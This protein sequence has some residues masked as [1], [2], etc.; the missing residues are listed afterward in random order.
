MSDS[1]PPSLPSSDMPT[2]SPTIYPTNAPS[3]STIDPTTNDPTIVPTLHPT[4]NPS[5]PSIAP[6]HQPTIGPSNHPTVGPSSH[7]TIAP[8]SHPTI[9]P[10]F[11]PTI[12]TTHPSIDPSTGPTEHSNDPSVDPTDA[13]TNVITADTSAPTGED[14]DF[15]LISSSSSAV[16]TSL[17][18][19]TTSSTIV[20]SSSPNDN[21]G[22]RKLIMILS[23]CIVIFIICIGL[24]ARIRKSRKSRKSHKTEPQSVPLLGVHPLPSQSTS[25]IRDDVLDNNVKRLTGYIQTHNK[26]HIDRINIAQALHD[27]YKILEYE[28]CNKVSL[29]LFICGSTCNIAHRHEMGMMRKDKSND[30]SEYKFDANDTEYT[31]KIIHDARCEMMDKIHCFVLHPIMENNPNVSDHSDDSVIATAM[32]TRASKKYSQLIPIYEDICNGVEQKQTIFHFGWE[33][34]YEQDQKD[35]FDDDDRKYIKPHYLDRPFKD[36]LTQNKERMSKE[37]YDKTYEKA[38]QYF[39]YKYKGMKSKVNGKEIVINIPHILALKVYCDFDLIQYA[40]SKTYRNWEDHTYYYHFGKLMKEVVLGFGTT[41]QNGNIVNFYHGVN[42]RLIPPVLVGDLGKGIRFFCPL[43]TSSVQTVA[44]NFASDDGLILTFGGAKSNARYF[45][46][47][48]ISRFSWEREHLFLQNKDEM[49]ITNI[50]DC[51]IN[52]SFKVYLDALMTLDRVLEQ[53]HYSFHEDICFA[54][55]LL[56]HQLGIESIED[57]HEYAQKL[58]NVYCS[59]KDRLS[60]YCDSLRIN[61]RSLY[62][63]FCSDIDMPRFD[64]IKMIFPQIRSLEMFIDNLCNLNRIMKRMFEENQSLPKSC[65]LRKAVINLKNK[66]SLKYVTNMDYVNY[67]IVVDGFKD[68]GIL[69]FTFIKKDTSIKVK[70]I[71]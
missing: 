49:Q 36:E 67:S 41:I 17:L 39:N 55:Q 47:A 66:S 5:H 2:T 51:R 28:Q 6:L 34:I 9:T 26:G 40:F 57:M 50:Q 20:T 14:V 48:S 4:I 54:V 46:L 32:R 61:Y 27:F 7:P 23:T 24:I 30:D 58:L 29:P 31:A 25:I 1:N 56:E 11:A 68:Y 21:H 18:S 52:E 37:A 19:P 59:N 15:T 63:V 43:S 38:K 69:E 65:H 13:P 45:S 33:F 53:K 62:E 12:H 10:T 22:Q 35:E 64:N 70:P 42:Q 71:V 8:S 3:R 60:L 16:S 44:V